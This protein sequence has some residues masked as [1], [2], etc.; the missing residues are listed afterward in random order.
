MKIQPQK[1]WILKT[2]AVN[3]EHPIVK[4][5]PQKQNLKP[6]LQNLNPQLQ[7]LNHFCRVWRS[8]RQYSS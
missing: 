4:S 1:L 5:Q 7:G 3:F 6:Q 2:P 8:T